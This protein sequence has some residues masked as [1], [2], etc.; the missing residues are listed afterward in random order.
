WHAGGVSRPPM[1]DGDFTRTA[2]GVRA[3]TAYGLPARGVEMKERTQRAVAWLRAAKPRTAEDRS[4]RVL[5]LNWGG[6]D[7]NIIERS[8]RDILALQRAD[9]GWGQRDEMA[10]DAYATGLT[11][12]AL[13]ESGA[14]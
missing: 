11:L 8:G 13:L 12:Y 7:R 9:G 10:S 14:V 6:A 3:I 4:F 2:L 5:G 1:E